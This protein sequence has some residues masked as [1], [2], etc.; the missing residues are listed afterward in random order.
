MIPLNYLSGCGSTPD[1]GEMVVS[2]EWGGSW[3]PSNGGPEGA[4]EDKKEI[5][6]D[7]SLANTGW[8]GW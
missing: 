4:T 7:G 6:R 8:A 5:E 1:W 3:P 2:H